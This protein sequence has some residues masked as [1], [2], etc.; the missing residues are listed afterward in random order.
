MT[1]DLEALENWLQAFLFVA[2]FCVTLFPLLWAWSRWWSTLLGR[3]L[4]LQSV[5]FAAA[6][7][8]TAYYPFRPPTLEHILVVFWLQA[9]VFGL[10]ALASVLLTCTMIRMNYIRRKKGK[11]DV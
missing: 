1:H 10:I 5:A 7:D 11:Q 6:I 3:L 8:L 2:A 4:M 9:I